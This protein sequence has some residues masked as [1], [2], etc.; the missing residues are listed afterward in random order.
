MS[1]AV[2]SMIRR[3]DDYMA[4]ARIE[5]WSF[6]GGVIFGEIHEDK[7]ERFPDGVRIRTSKICAPTNEIREGAEVHT[8]NSVY[9]LGKPESFKQP[10]E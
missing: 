2:Q 9:L 7:K 10:R 6:Y 3:G 1:G 4:D 8:Q 5:N